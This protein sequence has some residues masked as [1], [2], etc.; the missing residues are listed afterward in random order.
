MT[1]YQNVAWYVWV[2]FC[3]SEQKAHCLV[4]VKLQ[5]AQKRF[6]SATTSGM[7]VYRTNQVYLSDMCAYKG[8]MTVLRTALQET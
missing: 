1:C 4:P 3:V 8:N 6:N 7:D 5:N 2:R